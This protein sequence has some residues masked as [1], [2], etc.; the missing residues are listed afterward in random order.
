MRGGYFMP[1]IKI[2]ITKQTKEKKKEIMEKLVKTM[3][4][5]TNIPEQAFIVWINEYDADNIGPG[6]VPLSE[7]MK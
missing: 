3:S 1:N 4:E 6:G 5:I 7:R 2:E